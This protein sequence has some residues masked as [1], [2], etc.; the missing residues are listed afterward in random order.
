M[1][2]VCCDLCGK[3]LEG[4]AGSNCAVARRATLPLN[5]ESATVY[6]PGCVTVT[7]T[8]NSEDQEAPDYCSA[9]LLVVAAEA[10]NVTVPKG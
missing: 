6:R 9:C 5:S 7:V 2:R 4:R 10:F 3:Q 1:I 8:T